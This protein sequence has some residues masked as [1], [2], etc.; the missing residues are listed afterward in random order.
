MLAV[1]TNALVRLVVRDDADQVRAAEEFV[2][3]GTCRLRP[4]IA[5]SP[6]WTAFSAYADRANRD[7]SGIGPERSTH[8]KGWNIQSLSRIAAGSNCL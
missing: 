3:K 2:A 4:L 6:N 5:I 1:D 8:N 7:Q